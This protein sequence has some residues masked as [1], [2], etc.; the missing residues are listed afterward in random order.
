MLRS[1]HVQPET[2]PDG[3]RSAAIF[4]PGSPGLGGKECY[5]VPPSQPPGTSPQGAGPGAQGPWRAASLSPCLWPYTAQAQSL[6]ISPMGC[7]RPQSRRA[8]ISGP[9]QLPGAG[10]EPSLEGGADLGKQETCRA[11]RNARC[12]AE[13]SRGRLSLEDLG[14]RWRPRSWLRRRKDGEWWGPGL[15]RQGGGRVG[16]GDTCREGTAGLP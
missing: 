11:L 3:G 15:Q 14:S 5:P 1:Q 2:G 9:T 13:C 6:V 7:K 8:G 4:S 12:K 16:P 10:Q